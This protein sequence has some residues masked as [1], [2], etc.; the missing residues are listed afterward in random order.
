MGSIGD[1]TRDMSTKLNHKSTKRKRSGVLVL[2]WG[3]HHECF[4]RRVSKIAI[5]EGQDVTCTDSGFEV[6]H[7]LR[8]AHNMVPLEESRVPKHLHA[9][10]I[11]CLSA[12]A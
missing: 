8:F 1:T 2:S 11:L 3:G 7:A 9:A 10:V 4:R 5:V 12:M 6:T